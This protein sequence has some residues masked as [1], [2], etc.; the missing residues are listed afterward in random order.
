MT[1][2]EGSLQLYGA[3]AAGSQRGRHGAAARATHRYL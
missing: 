2:H 1:P 3:A